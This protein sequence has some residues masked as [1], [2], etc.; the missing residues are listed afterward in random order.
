MTPIIKTPS[1]GNLAAPFLVTI[2]KISSSKY[3]KQLE[4]AKELAYKEGYYQG[5]MTYGVSRERKL[6]MQSRRSENNFLPLGWPSDVPSL[7]R[8]LLVRPLMS[9]AWL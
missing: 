7:R 9:A 4:Y 6:R 5:V 1:Y 3:I 8:G 2:L